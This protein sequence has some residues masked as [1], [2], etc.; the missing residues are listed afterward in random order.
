MIW[1]LL[2]ILIRNFIQIDQLARKSVNIYFHKVELK[3]CI[4]DQYHSQFVLCHMDCSFDSWIV[5]NFVFLL[6]VYCL[7]IWNIR[8]ISKL[9]NSNLNDDIKTTILARHVFLR[10]HILFLFLFFLKWF[11]W[12]FRRCTNTDIL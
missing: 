7:S 10:Q 12:D 1:Y 11:Q 5:T 6:L 2:V 4:F 9:V 3:W 8:N